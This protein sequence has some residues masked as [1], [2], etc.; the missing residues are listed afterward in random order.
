VT[1]GF[2]RRRQRRGEVRTAI[3]ALLG[4][5]PMH[6]YEMI[7]EIEAR[8][9]GTWRPSPGSIYPALGL[10]RREG[11]IIGE[12]SHN[13]RLFSLTEA[14]RNE[15]IR[16]A[17]P[18]FWT[19]VAGSPDPSELSLRDAC[20]RVAT[21]VSHIADTGT[22]LQKT[23]ALQILAETRGRLYSILGNGE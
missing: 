19:R 6:G 23:K 7:M 8:T 4:E 5:R 11:L 20:M 17:D 15:A 14:G 13:K 1:T 18:T 3:L 21:A 10:L 16:G 9:R 22:E 2:G 12:A